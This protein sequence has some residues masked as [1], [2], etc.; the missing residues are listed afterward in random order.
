MVGSRIAALREAFGKE[1]VASP[2]PRAF[3]LLCAWRLCR[4]VNVL[5]GILSEEQAG[6]GLSLKDLEKV[7]KMVRTVALV[8]LPASEISLLFFSPSGEQGVFECQE[9]WSQG[10]R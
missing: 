8:A 10:Q 7:S 6:K 1:S 2:P 3:H 4:Y 9:S 5:I